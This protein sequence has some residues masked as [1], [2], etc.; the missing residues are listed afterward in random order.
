MKLHMN[1]AALAFTVTRV[2][3]T[4]YGV[5]PEMLVFLS[6]RDRVLNMSQRRGLQ[7][8]QSPFSCAENEL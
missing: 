5:P 8:A 6:H 4:E 1:A 2:W 3:C 7:D